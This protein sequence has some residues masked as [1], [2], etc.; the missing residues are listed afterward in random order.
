MSFS[1]LFLRNAWQ[2]WKKNWRV[3]WKYVTFQ[4][5]KYVLFR[6]T[7]Q[8]V[9]S[10]HFSCENVSTFFKQTQHLYSSQHWSGFFIPFNFIVYLQRKEFIWKR[11]PP[12]LYYVT[13]EIPTFV[14]FYMF[15]NIIQDNT[16]CTPHEGTEVCLLHPHQCQY[17]TPHIL[18]ALFL[19]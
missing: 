1:R 16:S 2:H 18:R 17:Q 6:L 4:N 15:P 19:M 10:I 14:H 3:L 9:R 12:N 11:V 8:T 13:F 7:I 5:Y